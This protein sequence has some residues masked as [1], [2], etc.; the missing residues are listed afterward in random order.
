MLKLY[1]ME[2]KEEDGPYG[3]SYSNWADCIHDEITG[4]P[5]P[6]DDKL[7]R[8]EFETKY[9][10]LYIFNL[11]FG[12]KDF[13]QYRNWFSV[14]E[15]K[16]LKVLGYEMQIYLVKDLIIGDSQAVFRKDWIIEKV[17]V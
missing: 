2:N 4:R 10:H 8:K 1:R 5:A 13:K 12:F 16:K 11:Y 15:E 14:A 3:I 7:L 9:S 17:N 6:Y